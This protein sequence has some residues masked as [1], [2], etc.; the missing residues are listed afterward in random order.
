MQNLLFSLNAVAPIFV[1]VLFGAWLKHRNIINENFA[2]VST[3]IVFMAAL[4]ALIF[5]NIS[6]ADFKSVVNIKLIVFAVL[7]TLVLFAL[8]CIFVPL[9]IANRQTA[10]A[11]IQG[12][13]RSNYA[14]IGLPLVF[15]LFGQTGFAKGSVMMAFIMPF[16]NILAVALLVSTSPKADAVG[17]K[18]IFAGIFKNPLI[19]STLAA[20][21]FSYFRLPLPEVAAKTIDYL[22]AVC[23]PLALLG[24]GSFISFEGVKK[25]L[26]L[27]IS[28]SILR[29]AATPAVFTFLA[30]SLGF[31]GEELGAVYMLFASPT[32]VSSFIMAKAMDSDFGL[33]AQIVLMTTLFSVFTIFAGV[34]ILKTIAAI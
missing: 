9:F 1:I 8:L 3:K 33:A 18:E 28:A 11:F 24:I 30:Y 16:Y 12:V 27:S 22:A 19:L 4:P 17:K 2:S 31:R 29:T 6:E 5:K 32:A 15:N 25:N 26:S 13:F 21:P 23:V 34:F 14:V 7:S 10:G 20:L